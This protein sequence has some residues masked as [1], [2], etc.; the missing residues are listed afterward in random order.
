MAKFNEFKTNPTKELEGVVVEVPGSDLKL[1]IGRMTNP[2]YETHLRK[3]SRPFTTSIR[4]GTID[5]KV[6]E[7][8]MA[9]AI[10]HH[11]LLGWEN[12]QD[13]KGAEIPYSQGKAYELL[14]ESR[15]FFKLVVEYAN[16]M[17]LFRDEESE[18]LK[19]N[20]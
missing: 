7:D 20:S 19:G 1:R 10:S 5:Q 9:R 14:V 13:S 4:K 8:L 17:E 2:M 15:D 12:L 11:V 16:D 18:E 6:M 3:I